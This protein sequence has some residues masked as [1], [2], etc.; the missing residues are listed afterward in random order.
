MPTTTN[1]RAATD[2]RLR[3]F[4]ASGPQLAWILDPEA[5]SVEVCHSS[6]ERRRLGP[7][8]ELDGAHRLPGF[9]LPVGDR[10]KEWDW[11]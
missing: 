5:E 6:I 11:E 2:E 1:T 4:F 9:R 3:G 10:F 7:E 8:A